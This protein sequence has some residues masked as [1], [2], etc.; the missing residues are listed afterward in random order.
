MHFLSQNKV[1]LC[2]FSFIMLS[3]V[4][5]SNIPTRIFNVNFRCR[6]GAQMVMNHPDIAHGLNDTLNDCAPGRLEVQYSVNLMAQSPVRYFLTKTRPRFST[7]FLFRNLCNSHCFGWHLLYIC[8][9]FARF[10]GVSPRRCQTLQP[11]VQ[12]CRNVL[13]WS[14]LRLPASHPEKTPVC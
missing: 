13:F 9:F 1:I 6:V 11:I 7:G 4:L 12:G 8:P 2:Q 14:C 10:A 5:I 3:D